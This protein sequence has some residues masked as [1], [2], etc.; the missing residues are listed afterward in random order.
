MGEGVFGGSRW[1]EE[2][3]EGGALVKGE[4]GE[5]ME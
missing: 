1:G 3:S 5:G 4:V 2:K